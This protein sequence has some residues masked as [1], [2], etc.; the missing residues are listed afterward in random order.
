[1][2]DEVRVDTA[3]GVALAATHYEP[4]ARPNGGAVLILAGTGVKRGFY[5]RFAR[6][7]A[8]RGFAVLTLDYRGIGGSRP[9]T[10]R[11]FRAR[12][13]D[14]GELDVRAAIDWLAA[15][16]PDRELLL[17]GHS[18]GGQI[19]G[20]A[21]NNSRVR[22]LLAVAAQSGYWRLWDAPR[23]YLY[24][25]LWYV[26]MPGL[27]RLFGYFPSA[28]LGLGEELPAGVARQWACWCRNPQYM[29][30]DDG[31][32]LRPHFASFRAPILAYSFADDPF[33]PRRAVDALL[34][35]YENADVTRR[36]LAPADAG[37]GSIGHF[38]FFREPMRATLWSEAATWL[39]QLAS[40][41]P[42]PGTA[43]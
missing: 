3:D 16:H 15:R 34:G 12:M 42:V 32:P 7:L 29:V 11:A 23:Q 4:D 1:M 41:H 35:F 25:L 21:P 2:P 27:T 10:L 8:G 43:S 31:R 36:H 30:D 37:V 38:G 18:A 5:D 9:R 28:L 39:E 40:F 17:V 20:L 13:R 14:W 33:A 26:I 6:F 19:V 22:G 24:A